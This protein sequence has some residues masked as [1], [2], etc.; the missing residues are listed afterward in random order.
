[1]LLMGPM[2]NALFDSNT[3]C[4]DVD[5]LMYLHKAN[6]KNKNTFNSLLCRG[7]NN[8]PTCYH[9]LHRIHISFSDYY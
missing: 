7:K 2:I 5:V 3:S 4:L 1:M 6:F 8:K 9:D